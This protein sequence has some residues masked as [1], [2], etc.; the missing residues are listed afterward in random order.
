M[1]LV[2]ELKSEWEFMKKLATK[3]KKKIVRKKKLI[4]RKI[5]SDSDFQ[6][7][8]PAAMQAAFEAYVVST[9]FSA[10]L[11]AGSS[12]VSYVPAPSVT[13]PTETVTF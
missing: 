11:V 5:M 3:L 4:E 8:L 12:T 9:G 2:T 1:W 6:A 13:P 10:I 7:G